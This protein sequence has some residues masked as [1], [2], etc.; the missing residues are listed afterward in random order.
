MY[1][2]VSRQRHSH[3]SRAPLNTPNI[4]SE[5]SPMC[6][7]KISISWWHKRYWRWETST[8]PSECSSL[9]WNKKKSTRI[10]FWSVSQKPSRTSQRLTRIKSF[11]S[12][13]NSVKK[14]KVHRKKYRF[15]FPL[16]SCTLKSKGRTRACFT[17][18]KHI[19]WVWT[20]IHWE[21][22]CK[23]TTYCLKHWKK[24]TVSKFSLRNWSRA[25]ILS[26]FCR[27]RT[28]KIWTQLIFITSWWPNRSLSNGCSLSL[29]KT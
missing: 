8:K 23:F 2:W 4:C 21:K 9:F 24:K 17:Q 19:K 5:T 14:W 16:E 1:S 22:Y 27:H 12:L 28:A 10:W 11:P 3:K 25:W 7:S 15:M 26:F 20:V 18:K 29:S 13:S 6:M